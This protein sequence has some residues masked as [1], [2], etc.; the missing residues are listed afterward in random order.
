MLFPD[1]RMAFDTVNYDIF[2]N[3]L[4]QAELK[5]RVVNWLKSYVSH[6]RQVTKINN[7]KSNCRAVTCGVP[8]A[9]SGPLLFTTYI[10]VL[11]IH[12]VKSKC[13]LYADDTAVK[14]QNWARR[15]TG[16]G[17]GIAGCLPGGRPIEAPAQTA[18]MTRQ[19]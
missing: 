7:I 18:K 4:K 10:N 11:S 9:I 6:Q 1:L 14:P 15:K 2:L 13:N 5:Y 3:K 12:L 8:Q 17:S 19:S 16:H